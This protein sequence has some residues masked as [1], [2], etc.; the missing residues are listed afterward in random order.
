M[1]LQPSFDHGATS[2]PYGCSW[3]T[4]VELWSF[5]PGAISMKM[6]KLRHCQE[7][8]QVID[9]TGQSMMN[10]FFVAQKWHHTFM[11]HV[12]YQVLQAYV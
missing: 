9:F 2:R 7:I 3:L 5:S 11:F 8:L 6:I 1:V 10:G 12:L 4:M